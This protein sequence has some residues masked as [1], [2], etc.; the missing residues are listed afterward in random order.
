MARIAGLALA[1]AL[2]AP[3]C[4]GFALRAKPKATGAATGASRTQ[5]FLDTADVAEYARWLPTGMFYGVTTNPLILQRAG[6][7]CDL[8][9]VRRLHDA[10]IE[11]YGM[12]VFMAQAWGGTTEALVECGKNLAAIGGEGGTLVVKLPLTKEGVAAAAQLRCGLCMTTCYAPHQVLTSCAVGAEYVAPYLGRLGDAGRDGMG[13]VGQMQAIA[14]NQAG[15]AETRVLVAS[16][17]DAEQMADLA[18]QGC[19]TFTFSPAVAAQLF[20]EELTLNAAADFE[21]AALGTPPVPAAPA[22]SVT[23][24]TMDL[25]SMGVS[26]AL[27]SR[28]PSEARAGAGG[29]PPAAPAPPSFP[30]GTGPLEEEYFDETLEELGGEAWF[31]EEEPPAPASGGLNGE[32]GA[33]PPPPPYEGELWDEEL[34][35]VPEDDIL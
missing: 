16:I 17:R 14:D 8:E 15:D 12:E 2:A 23:A 27:L 28:L 32:G 25:A 7:P 6:L 21:A 30:S 5:Y 20:G 1:L 35:A 29:A 26:E 24:P 18:A 3:R 9:T 34:D 13:L 31:R 4:R 11:D 22:A 10:C 33:M 19:D